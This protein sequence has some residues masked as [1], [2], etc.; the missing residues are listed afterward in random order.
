MCLN[1][2]NCFLE[3]RNLRNLSRNHAWYDVAVF[4]LAAEGQI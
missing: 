4:P 2:K 1:K 3:R